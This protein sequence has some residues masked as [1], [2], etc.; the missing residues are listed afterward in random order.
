MIKNFFS[1]SSIFFLFSIFNACYAVNNFSAHDDP[2]I[3]FT[4]VEPISISVNDVEI[5]NVVGGDTIN[6]DA[7]VIRSKDPHRTATCSSSSVVLSDDN[8]NEITSLNVN[9]DI[10]CSVLNISGTIPTDTAV[11]KVYHGDILVTY[12]YDIATIN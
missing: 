1:I 7:T 6:H 5:H 4:F 12:A 10:L 2:Y 8:N 11:D 3:T 9:F